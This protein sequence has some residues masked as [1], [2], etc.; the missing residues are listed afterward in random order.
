MGTSADQ[1][2]RTDA[3]RASIRAA[4][5]KVTA[6][7]L[8]V[9][10]AVQDNPHSSTEQV[11]AVVRAVLNGSS[12]QAV[13]GILAVFTGAGLVRRFDPPGSPALF[14]CRV[15]DNHHHLVCIRCG[16]IRDVDCV[17]GEA[18]CLAPS[19]TSGFAVL[20]ANVTFTGLCEE[21]QNP[22]SDAIPV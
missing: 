9:L 18:P 10:Q 14:E 1:H 5:L 22:P 13:Y 4:G 8:A 6:P 3:L 11:T 12:S 16:A 2:L 7:R 17:V 21:C 20:T 15:G 19:D